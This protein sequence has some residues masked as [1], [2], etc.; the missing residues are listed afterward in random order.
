M[1]SDAYFMPLSAISAFLLGI[2]LSFKKIN[3]KNKML[4]HD[5]PKGP[6]TF[7]QK[8]QNSKI[9]NTFVEKMQTIVKCV[10]SEVL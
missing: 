6:K 2:F 7:L 9:M 4:V 10:K 1:T 8:F 5:L 3:P